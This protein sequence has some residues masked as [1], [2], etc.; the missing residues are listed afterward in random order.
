[1]LSS[2]SDLVLRLIDALGYS[3]F[4]L[5]VVLETI[6]PVIPSEVV[7]TLGGFAASR[8]QFAVVPTIL[9][10]TIG[11]MVG[12]WLLYGVAAYFGP[13][14][15][16]TFVRRYGRW[17]HVSERD[18]EAAEGWFLRWS[19]L[20]VGVCR[21]IPVIRVLIS[22]PAGFERMSFMSFTIST[23]IGSVIWN[24]AFILAGYLLGEQWEHVLRYAGYFQV[25]A[26]AA[27]ALGLGYL[28]FWIM[29]RRGS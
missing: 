26:L 4:A 24:T 21:C 9:V 18:L 27:M 11:S 20:A 17:A 13:A 25:A 22:L 8:G 23:A 6:I 14:P 10:A 28:A 16:H 29:R 3:G 12:A 5:I 2:L 19:T 7:L 1:M 15:L